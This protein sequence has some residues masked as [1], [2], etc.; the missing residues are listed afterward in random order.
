VT[1]SLG[2]RHIAYTTDLRAGGLVVAMYVVA[3]CGSLI[4][5]SYRDVAIFGVLNLIAMA[6]FAQLA[7]DGFASLW[8]AWAAVASGAFAVHL[9]YGNDGTSRVTS[10][11]EASGA[12]LEA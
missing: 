4:L 9:R 6:V 3:T 1:A 5:S 2:T 10:R 7:V 12:R 11:E 8:C